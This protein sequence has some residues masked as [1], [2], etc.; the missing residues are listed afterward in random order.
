MWLT[1]LIMRLILLINY[2]LTNTQILR[3]RKAC[4]NDL[5][6]NIK[7]SKTYLSKV[8]QYSVFN[9]LDKIIKKGVLERD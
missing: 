9:I 5:S 4:A 1:I 6:A 2:L 7:F 3:L 8:I